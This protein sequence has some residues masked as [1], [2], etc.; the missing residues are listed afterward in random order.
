M[1]L[2]L[3]LGKGLRNLNCCFPCQAYWK[4]V[5]FWAQDS[6]I[7]PNANYLVSLCPL[8]L[9]DSYYLLVI[10]QM[11]WSDCA[12]DIQSPLT[13]LKWPLDLFRV[14]FDDLQNLQIFRVFSILLENKK[15]SFYRSFLWL[16]FSMLAV[17]QFLSWILFA[18][19]K[20]TQKTG[21]SLGH[22]VL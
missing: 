21:I 11:N 5:A 14:Q 15:D 17:D 3:T 10:R 13:V 9:L 22:I 16:A 2:S 18:G 19:L 1:P 8:K 6:G 20:P 4:F 7:Q 12:S